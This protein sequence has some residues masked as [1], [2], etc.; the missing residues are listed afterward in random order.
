MGFENVEIFAQNALVLVCGFTENN[1]FGAK[2][3][4]N[5][6]FLGRDT[7][8]AD[9]LSI[10]VLYMNFYRLKFFEFWSVSIGVTYGFTEITSLEQKLTETPYFL[11]VTSILW[12]SYP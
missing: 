9:R 7:H 1:K 8:I 6:V 5:S 4:K 12:I 2:T 10:T 3:D 11:V